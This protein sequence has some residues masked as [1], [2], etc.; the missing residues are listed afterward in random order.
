[1]TA[2]SSALLSCSLTLPGSSLER[3]EGGG[4][5]TL[6][7][8]SGLTGPL[9]LPLSKSQPRPEAKEGEERSVPNHPYLTTGK[10]NNPKPQRE[11]DAKCLDGEAFHKRDAGSGLLMALNLRVPAESPVKPLVLKLVRCLVLINELQIPHPCAL[12]LVTGKNENP[13]ELEGDAGPSCPLPSSGGIRSWLVTCP[14]RW[15][16]T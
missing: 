10:T 2:V 1:M 12:S 14:S 7:G 4:R 9:G 11:E 5:E 3:E 15:R 6:L 16:L 13:C 8:G